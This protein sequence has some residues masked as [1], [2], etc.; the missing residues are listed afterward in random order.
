MVL[1]IFDNYGI[2]VSVTKF[3]ISKTLELES[4]YG[5]MTWIGRLRFDEGLLPRMNSASI[6]LQR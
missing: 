6:V 1:S 2:I 4:D 3:S 5:P